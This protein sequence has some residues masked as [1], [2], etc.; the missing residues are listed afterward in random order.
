MSAPRRIT[1]VSGLPEPRGPFANV[2]VSEGPFLFVAGQGPF[3]PERGDYQRGSI[4]E[5]TRLTL[6]CIRRALLAGGSD[7][8]NVVS[9][10][11]FLQPLDPATFAAMNTEYRKFF[12]SHVPARTTIGAQLL[13]I[14]VEIDC[15]AS[16]IR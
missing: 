7:P 1:N 12:G 13:G 6:E 14:D 10:R 2:V 8:A 9:C 15:I 3:D 11:V 5:Q 4:A 16:V